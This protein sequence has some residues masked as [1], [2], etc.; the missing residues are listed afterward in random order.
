MDELA[1]STEDTF[2]GIE[3][4]LAEI[5]RVVLPD[6]IT[7]REIPHKNQR[8]SKGLESTD[9]DRTLPNENQ[10]TSSR[11]NM[12]R[13]RRI[14]IR[15]ATREVI[16]QRR[17]SSGE[18]RSFCLQ[19][20]SFVRWLGLGDAAAVCELTAKEMVKQIEKGS[21]HWR[22]AADGQMRICQNSVLRDDDTDL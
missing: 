10:E 9:E 11:A 1:V 16:S 19:C 15:T 4:E 3:A 5:V 14:R 12:S 7:G 21:V 13:Y 20:Q 8:I 6:R 22:Q 17:R 2:F 18:D